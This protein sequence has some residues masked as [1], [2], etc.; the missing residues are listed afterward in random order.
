MPY[1][2]PFDALGV[3][4]FSLS[5][6]RCP[7]MH[8]LTNSNRIS[9]SPS[10]P[11]HFIAFSPPLSSLDPTDSVLPD[12]AHRRTIVTH[13]F[14]LSSSNLAVIYLPFSSIRRLRGA[15]IPSPAQYGAPV[16]LPTASMRPYTMPR[17]RHR[18]RR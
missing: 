7:T 3:S 18:R 4:C 9:L 12:R 10:F 11:Y 14:S 15:T 13:H 2:P 16:S 5:A 17:R 6:I 1:R 8:P